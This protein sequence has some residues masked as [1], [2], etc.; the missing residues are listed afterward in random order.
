MLF[1]SLALARK[2][3]EYAV[4]EGKPYEPSAGASEVMNQERGAFVTLR[5]SGELRGCI[6]Y[7]SAVKPLYLA[8]RDTATLAA[9]RDTRFPPVSASELPQLDYEVSVLSP[10][11]RVLDVRQIKVGQH[12]LLMKNG[13]YEGILLPQV[14][15]DERWDRQRFLE[16]TCAKAG[17]RSGCWKDENTDIFMF[18]AVV[19]G[20]KRAQPITP[21]TSLPPGFPARRGEQ[22]PGLSP[23]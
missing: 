21:E 4:R 22:A 16:E 19:F 1:R 17:M 11:R 7:T 3:V 14:P 5:K 20:E 13:V 23:Q 9:L 18:T 6:G 12:G 10:F 15:V 8:V 2:S